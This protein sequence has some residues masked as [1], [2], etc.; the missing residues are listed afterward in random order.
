MQE[1]N[2]KPIKI[3]SNNYKGMS[4]FR[5]DEFNR[6]KKVIAPNIKKLEAEEKLR[7]YERM[8]KRE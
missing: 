3:I 2:S 6:R 7:I 8:Q 1:E 4:R 5:G